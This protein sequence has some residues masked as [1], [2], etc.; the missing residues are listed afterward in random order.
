M[1]LSSALI[2]NGRSWIPK[3]ASRLCTLN[4]HAMD[5][6]YMMRSIGNDVCL[7]LKRLYFETWPSLEFNDIFILWSFWVVREHSWQWVLGSN[8]FVGARDRTCYTQ[9][10]SHTALASSY[11]IADHSKSTLMNLSLFMDEDC[12]LKLILAWTFHHEII[13]FIFLPILFWGEILS[14]TINALVQYILWVG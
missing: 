5:L 9:V 6:Q 11:S 2:S 1:A 10:P 14:I 8:Q 3:R 4:V 12:I 13:E 7:I